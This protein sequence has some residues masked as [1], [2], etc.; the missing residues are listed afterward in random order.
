MNAS[1]EFRMSLVLAAIQE[2]VER[3]DRDEKAESKVFV[4]ESELRTIFKFQGAV[5]LV[6]FVRRVFACY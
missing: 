5:K 6:N 3:K 2:L 1:T 4:S